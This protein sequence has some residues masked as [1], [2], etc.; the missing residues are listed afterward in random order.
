MQ[1]GLAGSKIGYTVGMNYT[2][3]AKRKY[4]QNFFTD[5]DTLSVCVDMMKLQPNDHVLEIGPGTGVLTQLLIER[6][7]HLTAIEI[8]RELLELLQI[9]LSH[10]DRIELIGGNFMRWPLEP[11]CERAP[12]AKRK[13][14]A[15]IPYHLTSD[16]LM[17]VINEKGLRQSGVHPALPYFSDIFMMVQNEVAQKL[18]APPGSK[19]YGVFNITINLAAEAE[20]LAILPKEF[21]TPR[22]KVDSAL[23]HLR[24]RLQPVVEIADQSLF[25]QLVTRIFQLRR[26]TLRNV[27]RSLDL[28]EEVWPALEKHWDLQLRGETLSLTEL[29]ALAKMLSA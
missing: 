16:I 28:A 5:S 23:I 14:V 10:D 13:L 20:V 9:E 3:R 4:S 19:D 27:L 2:P 29:A 12:L 18:V 8:D 6:V 7:K 15:N 24:P 25:W 22:P 26:K 21:F 17:K 11:W 1:P